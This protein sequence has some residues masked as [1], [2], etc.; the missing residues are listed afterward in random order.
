MFA[1]EKFISVLLSASCPNSGR[2][3]FTE[4]GTQGNQIL[5]IF[6]LGAGFVGFLFRASTYTPVVDRAKFEAA[7]ITW[8]VSFCACVLF[9][10]LN[11][12]SE[13]Q[14]KRPNTLSYMKPCHDVEF[15][16]THQDVQHSRMLIPTLTGSHQQLLIHQ[17]WRLVADFCSRGCGFVLWFSGFVTLMNSF[18]M[19]T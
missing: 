19:T 6:L 15:V 3:S 2:H 18:R 4:M 17:T 1:I 16:P 5:T 10:T 14:S 7:Y 11:L 13:D 8:V 9:F 12:L